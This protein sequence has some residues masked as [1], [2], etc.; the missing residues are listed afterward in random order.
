MTIL[1]LCECEF[2]VP[3]GINIRHEHGNENEWA[4]WVPK[5]DVLSTKTLLCNRLFLLAINWFCHTA[6]IHTY[7]QR[8][9][10]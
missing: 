5:D 7:V 1:G 8:T 4:K 3:A 6:L 2:C 10:Y 9:P